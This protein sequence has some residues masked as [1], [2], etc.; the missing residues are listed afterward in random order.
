MKPAG[1]DAAGWPVRFQIGLKGTN[2][3]TP[4]TVQGAPRPSQRPTLTG[5]LASAGVSSTS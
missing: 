5:G 3:P 2:A 4:R 1:T